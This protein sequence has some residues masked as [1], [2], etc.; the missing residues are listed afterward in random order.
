MSGISL[1]KDEA[2]LLDDIFPT[3]II[4][5]DPIRF[6]HPLRY[7]FRAELGFGALSAATSPVVAQEILEEIGCSFASLVCCSV[8]YGFELLFGLFFLS[9][10]Y[11]EM[12][13]FAEIVAAFLEFVPNGLILFLLADS[14]VVSC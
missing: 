1:T 9:R 14:V 7:R 10:R 12:A 6:S 4:N 3:W 2:M 13:I 5:V 8:V 11:G